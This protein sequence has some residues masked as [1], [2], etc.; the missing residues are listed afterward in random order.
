MA[1]KKTEM[2][3]VSNG[4]A[5]GIATELPYT[6][7][8]VIEGFKPLLMHAW[9][10]DAVQAKAEAKKGSKAKKTD[11]MESYVYR[12]EDGEICLPGQYLHGSLADMGKYHP[13]KRSPRKSAHDLIREGLIVGPDLAKLGKKSWDFEHRGRAVVQR[14]AITRT[15][16]A[17]KP[18]WQATFEIEVIM[19]GYID[20]AWL[21]QL[22]SDA[23]RFKG[24]AD[25]RP[26]FGRYN[27]K[28]W[29]ALK[30]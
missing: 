25:Y 13:D 9:N 7:E 10:C 30:R 12:D 22:I 14:N 6:M 16:P 8:V 17:F 23:G 19:P 27:L 3:G 26:T 28:R 4:A 5:M 24:I 21:V 20:P 29:E 2:D 18:G 11:D 15:W 1:V